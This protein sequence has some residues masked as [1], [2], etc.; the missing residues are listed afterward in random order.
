MKILALLS[1]LILIACGKAPEPDNGSVQNEALMPDGSNVSGPY[2]AKLMPV[3]HNFHFQTLG[4]VHITRDGDSFGVMVKMEHSG[5]NVWHRQDVYLGTR[6]PMLQDDTNHDGYIDI[7][8]GR[9]AFG[10]IILPLDGD[11][12]SQYGGRNEYPAASGEGD[13]T[14]IR[15]GSFDRF[16]QDIKSED[17]NLSDQIVKID[18]GDGVSFLNKVVIV[19]GLADNVLLPPSVAS[20]NGLSP[21]TT[22]P[23][24]CG[25]FKRTTSVPTELAN[26]TGNTR[27]VAPRT[28]APTPTPT[29]I[30]TPT[31][32]APTPD[33]IP[34]PEPEEDD[35]ED[36]GWLCRLL[37]NCRRN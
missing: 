6:C 2:V 21:H 19:Q 20:E 33:P 28:P 4:N 22:L 18:S 3:N 1:L 31:D 11:I 13:Y 23:I 29:P 32:P 25:Y 12:D 34:T 36:D 7:I 27:V 10:A 37:G 8:E 24:A 15:T 9:A 35:D 5:D 16:F 26:R 30:P 14:Y 17:E